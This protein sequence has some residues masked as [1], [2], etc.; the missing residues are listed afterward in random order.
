LLG[1]VP[2][3]DSGDPAITDFANQPD[4]LLVGP[5]LVQ[6]QT[7]DGHLQPVDGS[8]VTFTVATADA[9][10][11]ISEADPTSLTVRAFD[12]TLGGLRQRPATVAPNPDGSLTV[13]V[14]AGF[15]PLL[16][17]LPPTSPTPDEASADPTP[18]SP[19]PD[20]ASADSAPTSPTPD[21]ATADPSPATPT[22]DEASA[23]ATPVVTAQE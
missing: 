10:L 17:D 7:A 4:T 11:L 15:S 21:E 18:A 5:I 13:D 2:A 14:A 1:Y 23:D 9:A 20:E 3:L 8:A 16:A 6:L 22:P 19:T 12:P